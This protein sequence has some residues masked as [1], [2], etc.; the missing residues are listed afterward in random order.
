MRAFIVLALSMTLAG[1]SGMTNEEIVEAT[2]Y[3]NDNGLDSYTVM[4]G[5]TF[6]TTKVICKSYDD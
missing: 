3:C 2:K 5:W 6:E 1:C 4:N